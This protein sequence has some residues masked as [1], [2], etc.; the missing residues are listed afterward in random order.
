MF[1]FDLVGVVNALNLFVSSRTVP[2]PGPLDVL[3]L[4]ETALAA[5]AV[6]LCPI[7]LRCR[8]NAS[9]GGPLTSLTVVE[10]GGGPRML[11][12]L[13]KGGFPKPGRGKAEEGGFG[14]IWC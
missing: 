8:L 6:L 1:A 4:C 11:D 13:L 10:L 12:V 7:T 9:G 14:C 3:S 2:F 5:F